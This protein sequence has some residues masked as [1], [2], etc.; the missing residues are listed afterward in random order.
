MLTTYD[1]K[2]EHFSFFLASGNY[3]QY[4]QLI[5]QPL[6]QLELLHDHFLQSFRL[7]QL[8]Q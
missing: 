4:K 2:K 5:K 6:P 1:A 8:P 3:S 7:R